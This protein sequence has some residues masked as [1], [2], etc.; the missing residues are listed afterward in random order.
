MFSYMIDDQIQLAIPRPQSNGPALFALLDADRATIGRFLPWV[1]EIQTVTDEQDS[2]V[3]F[4]EHFGHNESLNTVIWVDYQPAGMI[5]FNHFYNN[6]SADIGYWLGAPF[7]GQGIMHRAVLGFSQLGF[8]E[9]GLNKVIIRAA[10]DNVE[11]NAVAKRAGFHLDG[12]HRD[13]E[14]L[15]DGFH[16]ENEWSLLTSDI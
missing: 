10:T 2:L 15:A 13:G 5:S 7:R 14:R 9:A 8:A 11:S 12:T 4:N 6:A 16:D 3:T 1:A